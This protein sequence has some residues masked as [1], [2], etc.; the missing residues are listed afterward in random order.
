MK[1]L[2]PHNLDLYSLI[3]DEQSY[4]YVSNTS[5]RISNS[6]KKGSV[7]RKLIPYFEYFISVCIC[8]D[9]AK[10]DFK[11][12]GFKR[13]RITD[14]HHVM[15]DKKMRQVINF[16][17]KQQIIE[18]K[19][20]T[21]F[22]TVNGRQFG[23]NA[24]YFRLL[25]PYNGKTDLREIQ[26]NVKSKVALNPKAKLLIGKNPVI[27]HQFEL[28]SS[29]NFNVELAEIRANEL[30]SKGLK[31]DKQFVSMMDYI[32]RLRKQSVLF[33]Y[34]EQTGRIFTI[35]NLCHKELREFF[36]VKRNVRLVELDFATFNI[37]VL[38]KLVDDSITIANI[39]ERLIKE[40]ETM[41]NWLKSDFYYNI[42]A[43]SKN[44]NVEI[45]RDDAKTLALK[46]WQN[47]RIDSWHE[48]TK[49]MKTLFPE[50]T[51]VMN[52]LKGNNYVEYL[53]YSSKFMRIE[54]QLVQEIYGEFISK[55]PQAIIYNIFD[56]FM[57]E[58][59]YKDN[60]RIIMEDCSKN[61]FKREV[62]VKEK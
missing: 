8:T 17:V 61:Y 33:K 60:L 44:L 1:I 23:T 7:L 46:H 9:E 2:L 5:G 29:Y 28:C 15:S 4:P 53:D 16:L 34:N 40:L 48:E 37:Q 38:H 19:H 51:K 25:E 56:S 54:S 58:E 24:K 30:Y 11:V 3:K 12:T 26:L 13:I 35:I 43:V 47:A 41:A 31:N 22:I 62:K 59:E 27:R 39:N 49:I 14:V 18:V 52:K 45:S 36:E 20:T 42:Q 55:Y 10:G 32:E 21:D 57:V 6:F 50:I